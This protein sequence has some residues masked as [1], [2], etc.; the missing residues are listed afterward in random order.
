MRCHIQFARKPP[1]EIR[2]KEQVRMLSNEPERQQI[3]KRRPDLRVRMVRLPLRGELRPARVVIRWADDDS[4]VHQFSKCVCIA[5]LDGGPQSLDERS[6][7]RI[8]RRIVHWVEADDRHGLRLSQEANSDQQ[9][10]PG[11]ASLLFRPVDQ[12]PLSDTPAAP[13]S[14]RSRPRPKAVYGRPE[15]ASAARCR[16]AARIYPYRWTPPPRPPHTRPPPAVC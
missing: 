5:R 8:A 2:R 11:R 4:F 16:S 15:S 9:P 12:N 10:S 6:K 14:P 3:G 13:S 7:R 1:H